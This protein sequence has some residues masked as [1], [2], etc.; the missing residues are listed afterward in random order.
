MENRPQEGEKNQLNAEK[1]FNYQRDEH[2]LGEA[3]SELIMTFK[4]KNHIPPD[5]KL[6]ILGGV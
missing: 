3:S 4:I 5:V 6:Q 1:C 2:V